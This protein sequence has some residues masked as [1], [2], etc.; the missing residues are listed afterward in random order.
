MIRC[1][2]IR[3]AVT[4]PANTREAILD[5]TRE[6]LGEVVA[7][8]AVEIEEIISVF[9]TV[10]E[11]LDAE[12]PARAARQLGWQQVPLLCAREIP[13]PGSLG[14]CIRVLLH[15]NTSMSQ[16]EIQH[17]YL[18]DAAQLRPEFAVTGTASA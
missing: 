9:F 11:D 10:T 1:R 14:R 17:V 12:H 13:V 8:N 18:R 2:G 15:V 5:A 7:R 4:V 6:L 3:G 16:E